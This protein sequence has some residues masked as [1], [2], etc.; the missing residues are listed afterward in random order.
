MPRQA[1]SD[2]TLASVLRRLRAERGITQENVAYNAGITVAA[3]AR[4]ERGQSNPG[5]ATIK[6]IINA[7]EI[8]LVELATAVEDAQTTLTHA[9]SGSSTNRYVVVSRVQLGVSS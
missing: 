7:L 9:N 5:W 6:R 2:Q 3:L 4:I 8:S 1:A